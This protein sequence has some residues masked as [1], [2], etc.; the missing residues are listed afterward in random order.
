MLALATRSSIGGWRRSLLGSTALE[1]LDRDHL[2]LL[3]CGPATVP[4]AGED[5]Y[6]ILFLSDDAVG[7]ASLARLLHPA[8]AAAEARV[9]VLHVNSGDDATVLD[10]LAFEHRVER[11]A[12]LLSPND[13]VTGRLERVAGDAEVLPRVLEIASQVSADALALA[14]SSHRLR[15]RLWGGSTAI[16][17][18]RQ[19]PLPLIV[20]SRL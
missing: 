10:R 15:R 18:L 19:S 2:P 12:G 14:T 7:A 16:S 8:V 20:V 4:P 11:I 17:L 1:V 5:G 6:R 13:S 3:L 9:T